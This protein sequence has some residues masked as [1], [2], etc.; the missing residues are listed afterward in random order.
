[1]SCVAVV[2]AG[3][4]HLEKIPVLVSIRGKTSQ[5]SNTYNFLY[6]WQSSKECQQSDIRMGQT[7]LKVNL[8]NTELTIVQIECIHIY[9]VPVNNYTT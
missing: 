4:L 3:L 1:M 7:S 9:V 6:Y 5:M 8:I 2:I